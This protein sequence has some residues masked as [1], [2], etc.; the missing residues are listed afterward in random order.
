MESIKIQLWQQFPR[1]ITKSWKDFNLTQKY[2][3]YSLFGRDLWNLVEKK[4]YCQK[5]K[6]SQRQ[7]GIMKAPLSVFT[8]IISLNENHLTSLK[9]H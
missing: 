9:N 5:R 7:F 6:V 8:Q 3:Y 4:F 2:C 1:I